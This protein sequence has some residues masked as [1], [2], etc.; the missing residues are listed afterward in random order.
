VNALGFPGKVA[1]VTCTPI[2][3]DRSA[4]SRQSRN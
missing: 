4:I 2:P 3:D 1:H